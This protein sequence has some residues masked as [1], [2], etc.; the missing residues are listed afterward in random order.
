MN[1]DKPMTFEEFEKALRY[2]DWLYV[3]SD[4]QRAYRRGE[5]QCEHLKNMA[6]AMGG[7]WQEA[8]EAASTAAWARVKR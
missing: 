1:T 7:Q 6:I 8:Y 4:D 5:Q 3:Y 2:A